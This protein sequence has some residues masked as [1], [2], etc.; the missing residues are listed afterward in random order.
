MPEECRKRRARK[1]AAE[2]EHSDHGGGHHLSIGELGAPVFGVMHR[3]EQVV[4][5]AVYCEGT[6]VHARSPFL[7]AFCLATKA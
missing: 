5:E 1:V 7:L 3:L 4:N 2:A 6:V